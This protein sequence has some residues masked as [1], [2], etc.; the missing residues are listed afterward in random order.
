M[1]KFDSTCAIFAS[2]APCEAHPLNLVKRVSL[3]L[4]PLFAPSYGSTELCSHHLH[5][6]HD[7]RLDLAYQP[8]DLVLLGLVVVK[9]IG[10]L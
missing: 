10:N 9:L 7:P 5:M 1:L 6:V 4:F 3:L 8:L 2:L